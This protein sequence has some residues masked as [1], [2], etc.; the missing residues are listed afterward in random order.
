MKKFGI[1]I[2]VVGMLAFFSGCSKG[3]SL[4]SGEKDMETARH[5]NVL[6]NDVANRIN[7]EL[8]RKKM[9]TT[10]VHVRHSCGTPNNCGPSQTYPFDEGFHDL[11]TSQLV[12]F[13][14]HTMVSPEHAQLLVD[15][16]VQVVYHSGDWQSWSWPKPGV[17]V[18]LAAG[19]SV[20]RDAPWE[21]VAGAA[22]IDVFRTNYH[23]NGKYEVIITTSIAQGNRYL[24]RFSDIY[25]IPNNDFWQYRKTTPAPEIQLT[26]PAAGSPPATKNKK[27][28][29]L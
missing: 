18:A 5:W 14:V 23:D 28:T 19:I 24:M 2:A 20:L 16:K 3:T 29:S 25:T 13:G 9:F 10:P 27:R 8:V 4:W 12:N 7:S 17:L 6:A 21:L 1:Y 22:A 11:L 26:G 15:Y